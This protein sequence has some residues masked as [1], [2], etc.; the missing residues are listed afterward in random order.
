MDGHSDGSE[1][2]W[3][4]L[5]DLAEAANEVVLQRV[6]DSVDGPRIQFS[7]GVV[8]VPSELELASGSSIDRAA[9]AREAPELQIPSGIELCQDEM[10]DVA[11]DV[12]QM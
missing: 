1:E 5:D 6:A 8:D 12:T 7:A 2:S 3:T 4:L 9:E 11:A 10:F